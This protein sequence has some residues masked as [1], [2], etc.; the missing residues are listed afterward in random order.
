[1]GVG[2]QLALTYERVCITARSIRVVDAAGASSSRPMGLREARIRRDD[3]VE[4]GEG[5]G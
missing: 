2:K 5:G 4:E 3:D 1:V